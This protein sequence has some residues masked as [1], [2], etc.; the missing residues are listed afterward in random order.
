[1]NLNETVVGFN[2]GNEAVLGFDVV[3]EAVVG[4]KS[5]KE[6]LITASRSIRLLPNIQNP[7]QAPFS[8]FSLKINKLNL[9]SLLPHTT[10]QNTQLT[11]YIVVL[12]F[13]SSH[14]N[15][16]HRCRRCF[17]STRSRLERVFSAA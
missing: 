9:L 14:R 1:V 2:E 13:V 16:H 11:L 4:T 12:L 3:N 8:S 10:A 15:H 17:D 7:R 6:P 5:S